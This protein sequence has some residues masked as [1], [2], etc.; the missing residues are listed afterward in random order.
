MVAG[1]LVIAL[2]GLVTDGGA[3]P[4]LVGIAAIALLT[5]A[6]AWVSLRGER[7]AA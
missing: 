5:W 6:L 1:A 7:L 2:M 4:M 3:R